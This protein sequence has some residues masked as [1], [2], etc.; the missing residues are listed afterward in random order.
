ML[1][2]LD[3]ISE[4]PP[5]YSKIQPKPSYENGSVQALWDVLAYVDKGQQNHRR[6]NNRQRAET[7]VRMLVLSLV[8]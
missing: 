5:W 2:D 8:G 6:Q 1:K 4:V 7:S 3:L